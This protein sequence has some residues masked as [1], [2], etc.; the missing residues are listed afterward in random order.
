MAPG[1]SS[2]NDGFREFYAPRTTKPPT[3]A[4]P[5]PMPRVEHQ[6]PQTSIELHNFDAAANRAKHDDDDQPEAGCFGE[7]KNYKAGDEF[8]LL[9]KWVDEFMDKRRAKNN[10][11]K[12]HNID[13]PTSSSREA[14]Q[15]PR[16]AVSPSPEAVRRQITNREETREYKSQRYTLWGEL[17][18][19]YQSWKDR[20]A[21]K[22]ADQTRQRKREETA[23]RQ[24]TEHRDQSIRGRSTNRREPP[25]PSSSPPVQ[26]RVA[27]SHKEIA[28]KPVPAYNKKRGE[29]QKHVVK[30]AQLP[31]VHN[32]VHLH[33]TPSNNY[34]TKPSPVRGQKDHS[35]RETRF[36]DFLH[37]E[38]DPRPSQKAAPSRETQWTY[39]VPGEDDELVRN[40]RFSSILD[41]A[42]AVKKAK[43]AEKAKGPTCYVCGGSNCPGGYRDHISK[44]W[45]WCR[46]PTTPKE[47]PPSPKLARKATSKP[48]A[49]RPPIPR[50]VDKAE[51]E[52][53][54]Y[55]IPSQSAS[56]Q[57]S[58]ASKG[59]P[60]SEW[61]SDHLYSNDSYETRA[62]TPAPQRPIGL[63]ITFQDSEEEEEPR[64]TPPLKDSKYHRDSSTLPTMDYNQSYLY[65]PGSKHPYAPSP[66]PTM[67]KASVSFAHDLAKPSSKPSLK[68]RHEQNQ[69]FNPT[70]YP[71][72]SP[73]AT[74]RA[75]H[76]PRPTS[77]VYPTDEPATDFPYPP[78][79]IP[80]E[81]THRP[82][83]SS[84]V[85][86][87]MLSKAAL[88]R[89]EP[90]SPRSQS[91]PMSTDGGR[92]G[93]NRRSSWVN[94]DVVQEAY[95]DAVSHIAGH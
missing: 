22:K 14:R 81:F 78:P 79:P 44:L 32:S 89:K 95:A 50:G 36:S 46:S 88:A 27:D 43:E 70:T 48:K 5:Q 83:R 62:T 67:R 84:S 31:P 93:L 92:T 30:I 57:A 73:P 80:Q 34:R 85:N 45:L 41:P 82:K 10:S 42:K 13:K 38:R 7:I 75:L 37:R 25:R 64:P 76:R 24:A 94:S 86:P 15:V 19:L 74:P 59:V 63:G 21:K 26:D 53:V 51:S 72:P 56:S 69:P 58:L 77:S 16:P 1:A 17:F 40:S 8:V 23:R 2:A 71:Y 52:D 68:Q 35:N 65:K 60:I 54:K 12:S 47:V 90:A 61:D 66:A 91:S 49:S 33:H 55:F 6:T 11:S 4:Q 9:W 20:Q 87:G 28:R 3:T 29:V 18:Y 39:A